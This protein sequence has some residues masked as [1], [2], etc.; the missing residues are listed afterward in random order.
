MEIES[1]NSP[2]V[3]VS[4]L[5]HCLYL[6]EIHVTTGGSRYDLTTFNGRLYNILDMIDPRTLL[7]GGIVRHLDR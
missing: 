6:T 3:C 5:Q 2:R 4:D 7:I 1:P